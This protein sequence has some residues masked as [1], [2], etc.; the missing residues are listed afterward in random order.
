MNMQSLQVGSVEALVRWIHPQHGF[1]PPDEFIGLA[2]S[3]GNI[4]LLTQCGTQ[5]FQSKCVWCGVGM[6]Q[7]S[8]AISQQAVI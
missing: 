2:E 4:G 3:S 8:R 7:Q 1:M 5:G 6:E